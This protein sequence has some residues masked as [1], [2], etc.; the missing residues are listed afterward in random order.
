MVPT[1]KADSSEEEKI[2]Y[3]EFLKY[4]RKRM[5]ELEKE[6]KRFREAITRARNINRNF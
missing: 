2:R 6:E 5:K 1:L 4:L 3:R